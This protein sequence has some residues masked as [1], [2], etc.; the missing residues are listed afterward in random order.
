MHRNF[1]NVIKNIIERNPIIAALYSK[2][3]FRYVDYII[4]VILTVIISIAMTGV[5]YNSVIINSSYTLDMKVDVKNRLNVRINTDTKMINFG[6]VPKGAVGERV[7]NITNEEESPLVVKLRTTGC[8]QKWVA[9][10][11]N[12][13]VLGSN[14]MKQVR[15]RARIPEDA[16]LGICTGKLQVVFENILM[17]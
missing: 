14:Q 2:K 6:G 12:N 13:F 17:D 8:M 11:D 7:I 15:I 1:A 16:P 9:V 10:S 5:I 3:E 4:I